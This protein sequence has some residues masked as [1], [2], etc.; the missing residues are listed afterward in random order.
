MYIYRKSGKSEAWH[1]CSVLWLSQF[2]LIF[3]EFWGKTVA[4]FES[5]QN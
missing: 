2:L 3:P 1:G 4:H 5:D